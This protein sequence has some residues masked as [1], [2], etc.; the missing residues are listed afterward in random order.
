M[1]TLS[2][3]FVITQSDDT[4]ERIDLHLKDGSI[5][6]L[7]FD[8]DPLAVELEVGSECVVISQLVGKNNDTMAVTWAAGQ[9]KG[10]LVN[11]KLVR[12]ALST[13]ELA[14]GKLVGV[15]FNRFIV[16]AA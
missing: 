8:D 3:T 5:K 14:N 6:R 9:R 11:F 13:R 2:V 7:I 1:A 16:P 4:D 15:G 10:S 12:G